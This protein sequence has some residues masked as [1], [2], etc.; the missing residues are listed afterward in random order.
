M[1]LT[2]AGVMEFI[3]AG[4][5]VF[6]SLLPEMAVDFQMQNIKS[7]GKILPKIEDVYK[8]AEMII[9]VKEPIAKEYKLIKKR[10]AF[11]YLLSLCFL[12]AIDQ[13]HD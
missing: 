9:K 1:A 8:K 12:W 11:V 13:G 2:P 5:A 7:G 10:P 6:G 3:K 4:H